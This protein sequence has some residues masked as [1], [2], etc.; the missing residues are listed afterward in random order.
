MSSTNQHAPKIVESVQHDYN[1]RGKDI[2]RKTPVSNAGTSE[3]F[4]AWLRFGLVEHCQ[5]MG[6]CSLHAVITFLQQS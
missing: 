6:Q 2:Q 1:G 4:P 5:Y 3:F